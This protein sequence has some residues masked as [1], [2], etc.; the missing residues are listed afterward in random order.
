MSDL[1]LENKYIKWYY[2]IIDNRIKM[3]HKKDLYTERYHIIPKSLGGNNEKH[4]LVRLSA[5]EHFLVHWLLTKM[6][7][8]KNHNDNC[9]NKVVLN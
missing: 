9:K 2:S 7:K 6:C 3:P 4:N 8:S 1:F 5:R